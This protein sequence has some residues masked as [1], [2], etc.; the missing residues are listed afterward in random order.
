VTVE[1]RR[2]VSAD[3]DAI[4]ELAN[5]SPGSPHWTRGNYVTL[6]ERPG[7]ALVAELD[8]ALA[9]FAV[10]AL[11]ADI[12][13]LESIVVAA[14][15][16]RRGIGAALLD[17]VLAWAR[18]QGAQRMELEVRASNR[19]AIA[20]YERADFVRDGVRRGYY[21]DPEEDALLMG[22]ALVS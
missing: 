17:A 10:A 7:V 4:L 16:R 22:L 13:E 1:I 15:F 6:E 21:R 18:E 2:M 8:D 14:E 11:A 5:R 9:G 20:L 12:A 19:A 3:M